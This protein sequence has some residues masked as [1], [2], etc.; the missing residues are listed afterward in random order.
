MDSFMSEPALPPDL[1]KV[2]RGR[3]TPAKPMVTFLRLRL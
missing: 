1:D 2:A 3:L